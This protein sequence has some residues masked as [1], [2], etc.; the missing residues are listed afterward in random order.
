MSGRHDTFPVMNKGAM[1]GE[2]KGR[3]V[4]EWGEEGNSA[5]EQERLSA[6]A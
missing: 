3:E 1:R 6:S 4:E 2:K 5:F